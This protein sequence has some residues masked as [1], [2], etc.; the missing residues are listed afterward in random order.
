MAIYC[1][2]V[3]IITLY[4]L[5]GI[6]ELTAFAGSVFAVSFFGNLRWFIFEME[7]GF[8]A[9]IS[10]VVGLLVHVLWRFIFPFEYDTLNDFHEL[11]PAFTIA[12]LT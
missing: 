11:F 7:T 12:M 4:A 3:F 2:F 9:M 10:I 1:L 6:V 8:G 5:A